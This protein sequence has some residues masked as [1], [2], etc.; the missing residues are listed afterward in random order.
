VIKSAMNIDPEIFD[1]TAV[2]SLISFIP[3][4]DDMTQLKDFFDGGSDPSTL[5]SAEQFMWPY[6]K[7]PQLSERLKCFKYLVDFDPKKRD[8]EPDIIRLNQC[9]EFIKTDKK[10]ERILEIIL[11]TGNFLNAGNS[12]LGAAMGF[13]LETLAKLHDTKTADNK[14]TV[15][16]VLIEMIKDQ[17]PEHIAFTKAESELMD[18][19]ARISLQTVESELNKLVKEF[20]VVSQLAPTI[21]SVGDDDLFAKRFDQFSVRAKVELETMEKQ[22]TQANQNYQDVVTLFGEDPKAMGPEEFFCSV[23]VVCG[24]DH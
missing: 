11:H 15:F 4:D 16:E 17:Q 21:N 3:T 20:G 5:G 23:E 6:G 7:V 24:E 22:F 19:G 14:Q 10:V 2:N 1:Q 12:R 8:L 13:H 9:A 18:D